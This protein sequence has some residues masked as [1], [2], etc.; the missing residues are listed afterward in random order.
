MISCFRA[1]CQN[2]N[3]FCAHWP[4]IGGLYDQ[5]SV[6]FDTFIASRFSAL[7]SS[8]LKGSFGWLVVSVHRFLCSSPIRTLPWAHELPS[9]TCKWRCANPVQCELLFLIWPTLLSSDC[10]LAVLSSCSQCCVMSLCLLLHR[11]QYQLQ[12]Q[13]LE[14][15]PQRLDLG[16]HENSCHLFLFSKGWVV[17]LF[18]AKAS[19]DFVEEVGRH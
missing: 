19:C 4:Y 12:L 14:A 7:W 1:F 10:L 6:G 3:F 8:V 5:T 2:H 16:L 13:L 9:V 18:F 15:S 17:N 11:C